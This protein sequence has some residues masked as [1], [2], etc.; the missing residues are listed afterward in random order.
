MTS[1]RLFALLGGL[2]LSLAGPVRVAAQTGTIVGVVTDSLNR[3]RLAG[4]QVSVSGIHRVFTTNAG[5][6][7]IA[8]SIPPGHYQVTFRHPV[9]DSLGVQGAAV[10]VDVPPGGSARA[11][12]GVPSG[13]TFMRLCPADPAVQSEAALFGVIRDA[14]TAEPLS[15]VAL[16]VKWG[17]IVV[18]P[19][20]GPRRQMEVRNVT[21]DST[22]FYTLCG[23][24][25]K[26]TVT[27]E[28]ERDGF[29]PT[30]GDVTLRSEEAITLHLVMAPENSPA[31][32]VLV[33]RVSD[34]EK[35]PL[36]NADVWIVNGAGI[37]SRVAKTDTSGRF[38]LDSL[39]PGTAKVAVR[40]IGSAPLERTVTLAAERRT[41][42]DLVLPSQALILPEIKVEA[43]AGRAAMSGFDD[44]RKRGFGDFYDP[45]DLDRMAATYTGD[46]F[47]QLPS[48]R[49]QE[50]FGSESSLVN[51]GRRNTS[52]QMCSMAL[53]VNGVPTPPDAMMNVPKNEIDGIEV[54][55]SSD[56]VPLEYSSPATNCGAVLIW[57]K[58]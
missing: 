31:N 58:H 37:R 22:G 56:R 32:A 52:G 49:L 16:T 12:L 39:T 36:A 11:L 18:D 14:L 46:I 19:L 6:R 38:T 54:F 21:T 50:N 10:A 4:A 3:R 28:A 24:P 55:D 45:S 47:R 34:V 27:A 25:P 51:Q 40:R 5:G 20:L 43:K 17:N 41:T 33:G 53:L 35:R 9:L 42:V 26:A 29:V 23:L 48:V 13:R 2:A 57:T 30:A 7:F 8:D 15:G 1:K 44:R